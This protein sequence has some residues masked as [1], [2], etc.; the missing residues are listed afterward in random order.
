MA[1]IRIDSVIAGAATGA[2]KYEPEVIKKLR[3]AL[4]VA[5]RLN[6]AGRVE[7]VRDTILAYGDKVGEDDKPGLWCFVFDSLWDQ[8]NVPLTD[9]QKAKIIDDLEGRLRR[10]SDTSGNRPV[11]TWA[12]ELAAV[13][14][15]QHYQAEGRPAEVKR[16]L[17]KYGAAFEKKAENATAMLAQAWLGQVHQIY[18]DFG[19][20]D[21]AERLLRK[22]RAL[23]PKAL[24]DLKPIEAEIE[25][26]KE[27]MDG[28]VT[29]MTEGDLET[30][31]GRIAV[32][33]LPRR[34]DIEKQMKELSATY[35]LS[36]LLSNQ[37]MDHEGRP[38]ATVGSLEDDLEGRVVMQMAQNM[39]FVG[40]FFRQ[41]MSTAVA[42]FAITPEKLVDHICRSQ[43]FDD[44]SKAVLGRG[45]KAYLEGDSLVAIHVLMPKIENAIRTLVEATG[46]TVL[47]PN[48]SGGQDLK[49]FD[50]LVRDDRIIAVFG[51]AGNDV[52][53]YMRV[54]L[55]DRRGINLRNRVFHGIAPASTFNL[56]FADRVVHV[57][58]ILA[59]L[60]KKE[61]QTSGECHGGEDEK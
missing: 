21:D 5:V 4:Q 55:T 6:D 27:Q 47:K 15:A 14:L 31:L 34:G 12:A 8:K 2:H 1:W 25:V 61:E 26:P 60:R 9:A 58:L 44:D 59:L 41:V 42:K 40:M 28:F 38:T 52:S 32:Y 51:K 45:I 16:V 54:L 11:N 35:P 56:T 23:G 19:L 50:E 36:F 3:H 49:I 43:L 39:Q 7:R 20:K 33:Y 17:L 48:R 37:I 13:R 57:L 30:A 18:R 22:V 53:L 24:N 10:L 29:E 46:G